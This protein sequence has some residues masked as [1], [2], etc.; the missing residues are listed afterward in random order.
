MFYSTGFPDYSVLFW[1]IFWKDF[2]SLDTQM[3]FFDK[4]QNY[5]KIFFSHLF[6]LPMV[7]IYKSFY[8]RSWR[9]GYYYI[10]NDVDAMKSNS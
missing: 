1:L 8:G 6:L 3:Y 5:K 7:N 10:V 9:Q 2:V 4:I